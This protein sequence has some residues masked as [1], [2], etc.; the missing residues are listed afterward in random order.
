MSILKHA[1]IPHGG[2]PDPSGTALRRAVKAP[3]VQAPKLQAI[4]GGGG[5]MSTPVNPVMQAR[6]HAA[7]GKVMA[8][9]SKNPSIKT[10]ELG[11]EAV[12]N[13]AFD[14]TLEKSAKAGDLA[15]D[16]AGGID[17]FGTWTSGLAQQAEQ[18]GASKGRHRLRRTV[19]TAGGLVGGATVVPAA[20]GGIVGGA[21]GFAKAQ[22]G[23]KQRLLGAGAGAAS[24]A[25]AP[26]KTLH[27]G[28]KASKALQNIGASGARALTATEKAHFGQVA[29]KTPLGA[30][31]GRLHARAGAPG[32]GV[33]VPGMRSALHGAASG[34]ITPEVAKAVQPEVAEAVRTGATQLALGG[35]VG[36]LGAFVQYGKGRKAE[37]GFQQRLAQ[38]TSAATAP[39]SKLG[40]LKAAAMVEAPH[41]YHP[42]KVQP[43]KAVRAKFPFTG[44]IDFQGLQIDVEN[45][46]GS[47]RKGKDRN[48]H[49]WQI[50]MHSHY[51]EIR[52][53]KG[54]DGDK[55]DVYVGPNHDANTVVVIHQHHPDTGAFD[56]DKVMVG[57]DSVEEAIGAYK[58]QYDKP[59]FYKEDDYKAMPIGEFWRWVH[60]R[61]NMGKKVA[62]APS[63]KERA[64]QV[65]V[66]LAELGLAAKLTPG[67]AEK[68]LG[69]QRF[70]HGTS[71]KARK[72]ILREGLD[73]AH[74][75]SPLGGGAA[76]GAQ[77][78]IDAS[79]GKVH[80]AKDTFGGR[81]AARA[82]A[83]LAE[84]QS[85]ARGA[86]RKLS[87]GEAALHY[88]R[89]AV[90][91]R[92]KGMVGGALPFDQFKEQ[93]HPDPDM[94]GIGLYTSKKINP[95]SLSKGRVGLKQI[96]KARSPEL[97]RYAKKNPSRVGAGV[98]GGAA[99]TA[100]SADAVRRGYRA[101]H[102]GK[103]VASAAPLARR[104]EAKAP[105]LG[106]L[107]ADFYITSE[108]TYRIPGSVA[109]KKSLKPS[110][111]DPKDLEAGTKVELE[112][113]SDMEV[114]R[115]VAMAHLDEDKEYYRKLA[116]MEKKGS[117]LEKLAVSE[118]ARDRALA[119]RMARI[120]STANPMQASH[121]MERTQ[122]QAQRLFGE[123]KGQLGKLNPGR[124]S[125][126]R[127][128]AA[129]AAKPGIGAGLK[130]LLGK[131]GKGLASVAAGNKGKLLVGAGLVAAGVGGAAL[132]KSRQ[133]A[134]PRPMMQVASSPWAKQGAAEAAPEPAER[135]RVGGLK[136]PRLATPRLNPE[137]GMKTPSNPFRVNWKK[138]GTGESALA[139]AKELLHSIP[140]EVRYGLLGAGVIGAGALTLKDMKDQAVRPRLE[141]VGLGAGAR[142]V[143]KVL[144]G[145]LSRAG[146]HP[147]RLG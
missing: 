73:P 118:G 6:G 43:P 147:A 5:S 49:E 41:N 65:G 2:T 133:G 141:G 85:A 127:Q 14:A 25:I 140:S 100:L 144:S 27:S 102:S 52:G 75:G 88:V 28:I 129:A 130:S 1:Q 53:T 82:H 128:P 23:V 145:G 132:V 55:L 136:Q 104:E 80:V 60:N 120:E 137:V 86:G 138:L 94:L 48:G 42:V 9:L 24:G 4:P 58:K 34:R 108:I 32:A 79:K 12:F 8:G 66:G 124:A 39:T 18:E 109:K 95:E 17:P 115:E 19:A 135:V 40:S 99:I 70:V 78:Y 3:A 26:F 114:A 69:A 116:V 143:Q 37:Q 50:L 103:K 139:H 72:S 31:L 105:K 57:Y 77:D 56:E 125:V 63:G 71:E 122:S 107:P 30:V 113:T 96:W 46:K 110:D 33:N 67:A 16:F 10:A 119:A 83:G 21:K 98:L 112:H 7:W 89:S 62:E 29:Q 117:I 90:F 121:L 45:V 93:F 36:G 142:T 146:S 126:I 81:M 131:A 91:P 38:G 106:A 59:G 44:Y 47:Y 101:A 64:Q 51:G 97:M 76:I 15:K 20:I 92:R 35:G 11:C 74:G 123:A 111:F 61:K 22:G 134:P 68:L 13:M 84:A 54:T 87:Q